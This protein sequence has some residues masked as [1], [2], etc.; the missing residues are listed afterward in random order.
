MKRILL[1]ASLLVAAQAQADFIGLYAGAGYWR[2]DFGGDVIDDVSIDGDL[3]ISKDSSNYLYVAFEHPVPLLPNI[4]V[5]RTTVQDS[6]VGNLNKTF[7]FEGTNF[8][9]GQQVTTEI[10]LTHNDFTFYYEV[11]DIGMDLD[12]GVTA[13][14]M[15]GEVAINATKQDVDVVLPMLYLA[16]RL[17]LPFTGTYLGA[18]ANG[19]SYSGNS[20]M[21]Y[22]LA[23]GWQ[24]ENFI[25]PEFGIEGGYR[26]FS[27]KADEDDADVDIDMDIDGVFV[28]LVF[29]F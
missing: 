10:D 24:T 21:D 29:H 9:V 20:L 1:L 11:I 14:Q 22:S 19:I 3:D 15:D 18:Q 7:N 28:N 25:F 16:G 8:T 23:V 27:L 17:D 5:A 26:S 2:G 4:K 12:I 6:G 13:R